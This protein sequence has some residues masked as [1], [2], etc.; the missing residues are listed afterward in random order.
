MPAS[1]ERRVFLVLC[2]FPFDACGAESERGLGTK[3][4]IFVLTPTDCACARGTNTTYAG[5]TG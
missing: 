2:P 1:R 4:A 5:V 3:L